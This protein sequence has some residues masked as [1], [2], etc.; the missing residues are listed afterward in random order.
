M[1]FSLL[2]YFKSLFLSKL[3]ILKYMSIIINNLVD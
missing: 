3:N 2:I 1:Y